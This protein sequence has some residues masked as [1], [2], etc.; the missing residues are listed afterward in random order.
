MMIREGTLWDNGKGKH[1]RVLHV[2]EMDGHT[3]VHYRNEPQGLIKEPIREY[4]C[5][6]E[7]FTERFTEKAE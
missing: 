1:F 4:S 2:V 6:I 3:W 7:A 5:Y